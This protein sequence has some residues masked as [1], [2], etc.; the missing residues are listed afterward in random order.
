MGSLGCR[1]WCLRLAEVVQSRLLFPALQNES[2]IRLPLL[3]F[4]PCPGTSIAAYFNRTL[5]LKRSLTIDTKQPPQRAEKQR[6]RAVR[7]HQLLFPF[8]FGPFQ[9]F[10][11]F[12]FLHHRVQSFDLHQ[13]TH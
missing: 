7:Q 10:F 12:R 11:D 13:G 3:F 1:N 6:R 5:S 2:L 4:L 8:F 9:D